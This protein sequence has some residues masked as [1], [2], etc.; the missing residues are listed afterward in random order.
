MFNALEL[1]ELN[2]VIDAIEEIKVG[3]GENVIA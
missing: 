2:I 3:G 1:K